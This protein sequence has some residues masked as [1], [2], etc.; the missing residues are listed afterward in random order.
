MPGTVTAVL[1]RDGDAVEAGAAILA[2]EAMKMEHRV[3]APFAGVAR[4]SVA[5]GAQVSRE[6]A[7]AAVEPHAADAAAADAAADPA[8]DPGRADPGAAEPSAHEATTH[9]QGAPQ[10]TTS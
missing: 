9:E 7:V 3:V 2:I 1:V 8:P 10:W 5:V 4:V 6:Q